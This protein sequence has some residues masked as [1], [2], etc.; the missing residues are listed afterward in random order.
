MS[1]QCDNCQKYL[2]SR[3]MCRVRIQRLD[4]LLVS[5]PNPDS[6]H[7]DSEWS[8]L[9]EQHILVAGIN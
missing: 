2:F 1:W 5:F 4:L 6:S 9:V 7:L 3:N 8:C